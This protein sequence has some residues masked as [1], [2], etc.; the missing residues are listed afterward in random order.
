M[1]VGGFQAITRVLQATAASLLAVATAAGA[2]VTEVDW[3]AAGDK[4]ITRDTVN[5]RD[6]LDLTVTRGL[7]V[8]DAAAMTAPGQAYAGFRVARLNEL[9]GL[10]GQA[11]GPVQ[12]ASNGNTPITEFTPEERAAQRRFVDMIGVTMQYEFPGFGTRYDAIGILR[13][14]AGTGDPNLLAGGLFFYFASEPLSYSWFNDGYAGPGYADSSTGVYLVRDL[15]NPGGVPEPATWAMLVSGFG[16]VG[17]AVRRRRV[18]M[19]MAAR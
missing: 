11:V 6:W 4:L 19:G 2:S 17:A 1:F 15:G 16:L 10:Y 7:S 13:T 14:S 3:N 8:D 18:G 5:Q 9:F 12:P